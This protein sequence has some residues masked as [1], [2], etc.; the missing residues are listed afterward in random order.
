MV[1]GPAS[2]CSS[3]VP[4]SV[5]EPVAGAELVNPLT[6]T[7]QDHQVFGNEQTNNLDDANAKP[8]LI[9]S[10]ITG[11]ERRDAE[12]TEDLTKPWYKFW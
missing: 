6:G 7:L 8:P 2:P 5:I 10:I 1:R 9:M 12:T 11:C 3:L 4:L